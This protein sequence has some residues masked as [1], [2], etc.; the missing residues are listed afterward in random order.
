M[1]FLPLTNK[2]GYEFAIFNALIQFAIWGTFFSLNKFVQLS[3]FYKFSVFLIVFTIPILISLLGEL[4]FGFCHFTFGLNYY[5]LFV[6]PANI[7]GFSVYEVINSIKIKLKAILFYF[8]F[9][10]IISGIIVEIYFYPQIYFYNLIIGYFP[11]TIYDELIEIDLKLVLSRIIP[12]ILGIIFIFIKRI[13]CKNIIKLYFLLIILIGYFFIKPHIGLSTNKFVLIENLSNKNETKHFIVHFDSSIE[14]DNVKRLSLLH[15]YYFYR[16]SKILNFKPNKKIE[17]F[18]Y[19]DDIQKGKLF[20]SRAADV[21]KPWL[22][23]IHLDVNSTERNLLHEII[24]VFSAELGNGPLKLAGDYNPAIIEGFAM[25]IEELIEPKRNLDELAYLG[26][27]HYNL[28][29][30]K[31]F[32]GFNF[33]TQNSSIGYILSGSFIKFLQ[34]HYG[35]KE[36]FKYYKTADLR[37]S[38]KL[39][40]EKLFSKYFTY[41]NNQNFKFNSY[42]AIYYFGYSPLINKKCARYIAYNINEINKLFKEKKYEKAAK[43]SKLL[44]NE[45]GNYAAYY[46]YLLSLIKL[47]KFLDAKN[48]LNNFISVTKN[49]NT[50]FTLKFIDTKLNIALSKK[51]PEFD[52][53]LSYNLSES[54]NFEVYRLNEFF[55]KESDKINDYIF[56]ETNFDVNRIKSDT[57]KFLFLDPKTLNA[58]YIIDKA[59]SYILINKFYKQFNYERLSEEYFINGDYEYSKNLLKRSIDLNI[60]KVKQCL[61]FSKLQKINWFIENGNN[62]DKN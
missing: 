32:N 40:P 34:K 47:N 37:N 61:Y 2:M 19:K 26:L 27:K 20:G 51:C 58:K 44:Y 21:T 35:N 3:F 23:Q 17:S 4:I 56:N 6:L 43:E 22:Y 13:N 33:F 39:E 28:S 36:L 16:I 15:E 53:L 52:T 57:L 7:L 24:H 1:Q 50:Y 9:L 25:A 41:I 62:K 30:R 55:T 31:L 10:L 38:Y 46:G 49:S 29:T 59:E 48:S 60:D 54:F 45:S 18:I 8:I 11:G 14:N 42:K 5:I 12:L